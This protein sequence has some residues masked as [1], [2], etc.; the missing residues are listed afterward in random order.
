[1]RFFVSLLFLGFG[2]TLW[3][4]SG[5][6]ITVTVNDYDE[7]ELYLAYYLGDNQY[8][9][10][11]VPRQDDGTY[12]FAG[13]EPLPGGVYLIV[14]PPENQFFQILVDDENTHFGVTTTPG[15]TQVESTTFTNSDDNALFYNY[16][17]Y[18]SAKRPI[19]E[20]LQQQI[21][22]STDEAEQAAL[23]EQ[24][25]T[26]NEEVL[27]YQKNLVIENTGTL[28]A[29]IIQA[30]LPLDTPDFE[31]TEEDVQLQ[32][33]RWTQEHYF[34][35]ID[36]S[37]TRLLR[38]PFLFSRL[39][40][41]VQKLQVQ[42]PDSI[43]KALDVIL[44]GL[45]PSEESFK[46]YLIHYLNYYAASKF[47]GMDAVYVH[48]VDNYYAKGLAP[49]TDEEQLTK[50]VDNASRLRPLLIGRVAPDIRMQKRDGTPISLHEVDATF[51]VLYFWRYDCGHCKESTPMMKEFYENFQDRGVEL[52][53]VCSKFR[54]EVPPCWEY[55]DE[56]EIGDWLHTVDPLMR[57]RFASIY[58]IRST[59]QIYILDENKEIVSKRIGAEQLED[60]MNQLLEQEAMEKQNEMLQGGD[61]R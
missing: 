54:D 40:Y 39:D 29:A 45:K 12:V 44:G 18:L 50:I 56:N 23:Q 47:V 6:E 9:Q 55:V 51:T 53:A 5:Y 17:D 57:S 13:D 7:S 37:D 22:A 49:W 58:D 24:L 19:A 21:A 35:N 14:M 10:D 26:V 16:L 43:A 36:L 27:N 2:W 52:F 15:E 46:F 25:E 38:S 41:Y 11:T 3:S 31:G 33:W 8:I 34:D 42:H 32:R 59:P 48:L 4:Q 20:Q 28:T 61:E 30:N 60:L 1:M